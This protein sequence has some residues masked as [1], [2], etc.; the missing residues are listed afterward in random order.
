MGGQARNRRYYS[1]LG[2]IKQRTSFACL[3]HHATISGME[4]EK[5]TKLSK[6]TSKRDMS[7]HRRQHPESKPKPKRDHGDDYAD[8][9]IIRVTRQFPVV[10]RRPLI[11]GM[12][13]LL[14][15]LI[16]W[17]IA[18]GNLYSWAGQ[19]VIWLSICV[20][21][22]IV[23]WLRTW[24]G[25]Y[26]SVFVLTDKRIVITRQKGFFDRTVS[27]L[28]LNNI[29]N[30]TYGIKGIQAVIFHFGDINIQTLSGSGGFD[31]RIIH[32][33]EKFAKAIIRAAGLSG[34][35]PTSE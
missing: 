4:P 29:Q 22:L 16:P 1:P 7:E 33:P 17:A 3:H 15:G 2:Q 11:G 9:D 31:L 34:S 5:P 24:V 27:E 30:V 6:P 8:E 25:W 10:M 19:S 26:Y 21:V 13:I 18:V 14:L 23:Y 32:K 35:T 28:A 12:L 20:V